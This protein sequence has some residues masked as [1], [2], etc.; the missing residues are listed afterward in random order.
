MTEPDLT[1]DCYEAHQTKGPSRFTRRETD[2]DQ[3]FRLM[4]LDGIPGKQTAE[5]ADRQ[6][7]EAPRPQ[8]PPECPIDRRPGLVD[9]VRRVVGGRTARDDPIGMKPD[10][11]GP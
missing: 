11:F 7:P 8:R 10:I 6:P 4:N 5:I 1:W 9:N 2:L 3:V